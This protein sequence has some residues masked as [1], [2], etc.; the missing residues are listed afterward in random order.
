MT[1][2]LY[3]APAG[4][5]TRYT[6]LDEH[7]LADA[8]DS[9]LPAT[10]D[11]LMDQFERPM[12]VVNEWRQIT[13]HN[14]LATQ[15]LATGELVYRKDGCL[16]CRNREDDLALTQVITSLRLQHF[17]GAASASRQVLTLHKEDGGWCLAFI[18]AMVPR[19]NPH[20]MRLASLRLLIVLSDPAQAMNA[21]DPV[22]VARCLNLTPAEARVAVQLANGANAKQIARTSGTAL[23]TV[24]TQ[25]KRV[26][27]KSGVRRQADLIRM[28]V[29]L[30]LRL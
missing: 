12:L 25:I 14:A 26:M 24:R 19:H 29:G 9:E 16:A 20:S 8:P 13:H 23:S 10:A 3:R 1:S 30:A 2:L 17:S 27:E 6:E 11:E 28:M 4:I 21:L 18:S 22:V 7:E 15:A 5:V